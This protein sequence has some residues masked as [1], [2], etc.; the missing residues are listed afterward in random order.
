MPDT[1]DEVAVWRS[2]ATGLVCLG[3]VIGGT[4]L[5]VHGHEQLATGAISGAV[6]LLGGLLSGGRR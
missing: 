3:L 1:F 4:V 5:G 6:G 2:I